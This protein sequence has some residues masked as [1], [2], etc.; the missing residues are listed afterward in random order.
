MP[1]FNKALFMRTTLGPRSEG[2]RIGPEARSQVQVV[3]P[4]E[5]ITNDGSERTADRKR[6]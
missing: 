6:L 1:T 4:L 5:G 3:H 2:R